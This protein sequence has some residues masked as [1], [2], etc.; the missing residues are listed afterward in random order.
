MI[1]I[2]TCQPDIP[3]LQAKSYLPRR[4]ASLETGWTSA[5]L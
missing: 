4:R 2:K 3:F 5:H 1:L